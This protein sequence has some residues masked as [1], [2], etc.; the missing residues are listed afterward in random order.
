MNHHAQPALDLVPLASRITHLQLLRVGLAAAI[1]AW[2]LLT[3]P[4]PG[5]AEPWIPL[6][7]YVLATGLAALAWRVMRGRG[8]AVFNAMLLVDGLLLAWAPLA[9]GGWRS[10]I[11]VVTLVH[12][13]AV[14]LL[15]SYRTGSKVAL[16]HSL[17]LVAAREAQAAGL[18]APSGEALSMV[19]LGAILAGLWA[20]ALATAT[21]SAVNERELRRRRFDLEA[22]ARLADDIERTGDPEQVAGT[23]L[24]HLADTFGIVRGVVLAATGDRV[25]P[26]C[27]RPPAPTAGDQFGSVE[28]PL[29]AHVRRERRILLLEQL[30]PGAESDLARLLPG[31]RNLLACPLRVDGRA[32]GVVLLE[33]G[34]G[35]VGWRTVSM[36]ERFCDHAALALENAWLLER[37]QAMASTDGLTGLANRRDFDASLAR[38]LGRATRSDRPVSLA[39][40]DID[41]FKSLNDTH[42]HQ[43]GDDVL[44]E[45]AQILRAG[46]R[47]FDTV[48]RYGGEEFALVLPDTVIDDAV[49]VA[50][51]V[52]RAIGDGTTTV[53]VTV[54]IGVATSGPNGGPQDAAALIAAADRALYAAK[55]GGRDQVLAATPTAA[56]TPSTL[57]Q[58]LAS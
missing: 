46:C 18:V 8:L 43:A 4:Q 31:A 50:E 23:L 27:V 58:E 49:D 53:P 34:S 56:T 40:V 13:A 51:R 25:R 54:S 32:V 10:P 6:A 28:S 45:V 14:A 47:D 24:D 33:H 29:V 22:L 57:T 11:A 19:D 42:G 16:W 20:L 9:T 30:Q 26:L 48:A 44:R 37:L 3:T 1:A 41:R 36:V 55:H 15:A 2:T 7:A 39:L 12:V 38:E 5:H 21:F 52:R 17:L 35:R